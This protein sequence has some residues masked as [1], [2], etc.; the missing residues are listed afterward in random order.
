MEKP[1][2][3]LMNLPMPLITHRLEIRPAHPGEGQLVRDAIVSSH[4][5]LS[6]WMPW[7]K[8]KPSVEDSE[9]VIR[10]NMAQWALKEDLPLSIFLKD[11]GQYLGGTGFHRIDWDVP[12]LE[13]GYWLRT[14]ATGHGYVTE[15]VNAMTAYAFR[16]IGA[17]R[18][19]IR[20]DA[21]NKKSRSVAERA[22]FDLEACLKKQATCPGSD[23][24]RDT[25]I[26]VRFDDSHLD[27]VGAVWGQ[28]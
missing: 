4:K 27:D 25:V 9:E 12:L 14:D 7:A 26:Y 21:E 18:V 15:A 17:R 13:I 1:K 22:G 3:I 2:P 11:S 24:L 6:Y 10:K 20:C 5:E 19:E 23:E 28:A 8:E 16:E